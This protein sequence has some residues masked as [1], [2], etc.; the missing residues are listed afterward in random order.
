MIALDTNVLVRYIVR[1]EP[2]QTKAATRL[3]ETRCTPED[4]GAIAGIVLCELVWVLDRGYGYGRDSISA[5]LRGL[6]TSQELQAQQSD[7]A[8][9]AL[10]LFEDGKADF[11]DYLIG[12]IHHHIEGAEIT[13]T[14]DSEAAEHP[15]FKLVTNA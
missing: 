6:L 15:L 2:T 14:F 13:Y 1:D 4:P 9:Q 12:L 8:W 3:I 5:V 10:A 11:S 7:L